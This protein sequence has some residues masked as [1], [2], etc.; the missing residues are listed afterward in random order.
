MKFRA[1]G[2]LRWHGSLALVLATFLGVD[3]HA[4]TQDWPQWRG[5]LGQGI[6]SAK[7]LPP[8]AGSTALKVHWKT[9]IPGEGCSSPIV[10]QGRVYVTTA[11][12]GSERHAWDVP[13]FWAAIL[14]ACCATGLALARGPSTLRR[15]RTPRSAG[16]FVLGVWTVVV[17]VLTVIVLSKPLWFWQFANP[18]TGTTVAPAELPWVESLHLRPVIVLVCGSLVLIFT[19]LASSRQGDK[20]TGRQGDKETGRQGDKETGRQ[21]D[22]ESGSL[23]R[24]LLT[25][26]LSFV[27]LVVTLICSIALGLIGWQPDW[28]F[29][30]HQPWLAWIV[31]GGIALLALAGSVGIKTRRQGDKETRS[32][33]TAA[34]ALLVSLSPCL[35]V[36]SLAG[37][38]FYNV[39]DD[40]FGIALSLQNRIVFLV[41]GLVLIAFHASAIVLARP[42]F[43]CLLVSLSPCLLVFLSAITFVRANYLQPQTGVVRAV[44]CLDAQSGEVLWST[45]VFVAA[46]EKRHSLNSLATPTPA[47]DGE[48]V[49]AYF[50]SGLA[51][52]DTDGR[53]LW[54]KRDPDFAGFIRYGAGSSV[55]LAGDRI[56]IYRDSE[57]M[58][59]G[60]HLDDDI[61]SQA[62]RR[63]SALT[64]YDKKTGE[65]LW[66]I[67]PEFSHDSYMT[68]LV[69][70]RDDRLEVVIATWKTLAGF[71]A[72][73]GA[74]R[75]THPY[76][77]QQVVSSPAVHGDCLFVMGGN[78][79]PG[80]ILAVRAPTGK[81][82]A[83]TIWFNGKTG[84]NIVS[85]VCWDG[86]LFSVSHLGILTCRDAQT[87]NIHWTERLDNRCLASLVAGDGKVYALDQE[88]TL[89]VYAADATA[90]LLV[91]HSFRENASAT[92][93]IAA[94][95]LFVRTSGHLHCVG[96]AE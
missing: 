5:A 39:P 32:K 70:T 71:D 64:A 12:V 29:Q 85:P 92:P 79:L 63:P 46:A 31:T 16:T 41:P 68:P 24:P 81:A 94:N 69:W 83:E 90:N 3:Q 56:I 95:M 34:C 21:G 2:K 36:F 59:H 89:H 62:N 66:S 13:A 84:G 4:R 42:N 25:G 9:P 88:G 37:W 40:E 8:A 22:K 60:D 82:P 47:C 49:Y 48:R 52:L 27:T 61:Q 17:L 1:A 86:L 23:E 38:L 96:N 20:E 55:A 44:V 57:F 45:P 43:P 65:A 76:P 93:A 72:Q 58:G 7:N 19:K 87:G 10:S 51:A 14:L 33:F 26:W 77:M 74:L 53:V 80:P 15:F 73:G 35:L 28:F 18:W 11:N 75:W 30:S 50:G 6:T 54:L 67:T 91:T 78:H